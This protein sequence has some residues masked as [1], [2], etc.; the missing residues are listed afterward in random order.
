LKF[1]KKKKLPDIDRQTVDVD[2]LGHTV[3]VVVVVVVVASVATA[4][5]LALIAVTVVVI[6]S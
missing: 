4:A 2:A 6:H 5:V 1:E 3:H